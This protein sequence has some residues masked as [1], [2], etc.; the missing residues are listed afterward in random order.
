MTQTRAKKNLKE[1]EEQ[2]KIACFNGDLANYEYWTGQESFWRD[3]LK[4]R[5]INRN[6]NKKQYKKAHGHTP[7][8]ERPVR[9]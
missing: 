5:S 6:K 3:W 1:A 8:P 4:Q 7:K 9:A 2:S